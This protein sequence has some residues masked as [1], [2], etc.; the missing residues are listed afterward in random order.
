MGVLI[1]LENG[2]KPILETSCLS[3][4]NVFTLVH[5]KFPMTFQISH[6]LFIS[7]CFGHDST[8]TCIHCKGGTKGKMTKHAFILG[9]GTLN[10]D[11]TCD[12]GCYTQ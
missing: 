9:E 2:D 1:Q 6:W 3:V 12:Q 5:M 11:N 7:Y 8:S 4:L 10:P